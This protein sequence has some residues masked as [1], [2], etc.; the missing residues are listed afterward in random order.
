M[1]LGG[2]QNSLLCYNRIIPNRYKTQQLAKRAGGKTKWKT[3][4]Q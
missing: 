3:N 2:V 1:Q 4:L